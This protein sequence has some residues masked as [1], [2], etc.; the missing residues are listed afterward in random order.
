MKQFENDSFY[1]RNIEM[2]MKQ[3]IVDG[4]CIIDFCA[5]G[6]VTMRSVHRSPVPFSSMSHG[7][8]LMFAGEGR[9]GSLGSGGAAGSVFCEWW[10]FSING[11]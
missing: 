8:D 1:R 3:N 2:R 10:R 5:L 9:G 6:D 4:A 7:G 11:S